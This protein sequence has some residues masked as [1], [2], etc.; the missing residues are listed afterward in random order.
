MQQKIQIQNN[1]PKK[2]LN[3]PFSIPSVEY[4]F[5]FCQILFA[6]K[7]LKIENAPAEEYL[8]PLCF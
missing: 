4:Y 3:V 8:Q 1:L 6:P 5:V 7:N 2:I